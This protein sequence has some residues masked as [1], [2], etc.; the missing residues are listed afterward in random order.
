MP[1]ENFSGVTVVTNGDFALAD[2]L[3]TALFILDFDEGKEL[4]ERTDG[5]EALWADKSYKKTY[6]SGFE[7]YI[8]K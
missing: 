1:A 5:A 2:A 4:I 7:N 8:K 3:S 6:S